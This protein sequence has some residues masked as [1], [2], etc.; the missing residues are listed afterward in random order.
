MHG[1]H[2]I[3]G[4]GAVL[5]RLGSLGGAILGGIF[6]G[7]GQ[8]KAN[9]QN[10][11]LMR[12]QMAFQ[13]RMSGSAVQRR[14][15]DL[16]LAGINPILAGK[17][18][19]STPAGAMARVENVGAAG[20][21]GASKGTGTALAVALGKSTINLQNTQ[22]AKNLAEAENIRETKPGI[23]TRNKILAHGEKVASVADSIVTVVRSLTGN[24]SDEEIAEIIRTKIKQAT[25]LLT[26]AMEGVANTAGNV[27]QMIRDVTNFVIGQSTDRPKHPKI[28]MIGN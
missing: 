25:T 9:K 24:K 10:I 6:S 11:A 1:S 7:R 26:N 18:D 3:K 12:E 20:V 4:A 2:V 27:R 16:K 8:D 22:S 14:M 21:E 23:T 28:Q 5:G 19:A 17:F 15:K 13:E